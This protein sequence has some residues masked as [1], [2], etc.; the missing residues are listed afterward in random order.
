VNLVE[1]FAC[2]CPYCQRAAADRGLDLERV[3][4]TYHHLLKDTDGVK[5]LISTFFTPGSSDN[6][7]ED[8]F[9]FRSECI[10]ETVRRVSLQIHNAGLAVGLDCF[11]P[12]LTRMVGQD[13]SLLSQTCDWMKLMI[14]PHVFGPAGLPYEVLCLAN[15]LNQTYRLPLGESLSLIAQA[16]GL[17]VPQDVEILK[18]DGFGV[19]TI[20]QEISRIKKNREVPIYAGVAL[21]QMENIHSVDDNQ[22]QEDILANQATDVAG[23]VISWDLWHIPTERLQMLR[24]IYYL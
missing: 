13:L 23:L 15:G 11:S 17:Q 7:L 6:I 16:C 2:F 20:Q 21:V 4:L 19:E 10:S 3:R 8:F 9:R 5:R 14:Y 12:C 1:N 18:R 22:I 24:N